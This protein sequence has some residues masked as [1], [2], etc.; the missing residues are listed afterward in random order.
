MRGQNGTVGRE[1]PSR[2]EE[3]MGLDD[4]VDK[5]KDAASDA[6]DKVKDVAG[7]A[8]DTVKEKAS[9]VK[10]AADGAVHSDKAEKISDAV[11][12]G[13]ENAAN[14]VT[15]DKFADDI[16]EKRDAVDA[17][18]GDDEARAA[19]AKAAAEKGGSGV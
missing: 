8:A 9:D 7:D 12:D 1:A 3:T 13:A 18:I 4:I 10:D 19:A 15:R 17:K 6:A 11:L 14:F 2:R 5:A 16:S